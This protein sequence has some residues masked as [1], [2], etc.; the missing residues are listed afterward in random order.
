MVS[1]SF[2]EVLEVENKASKPIEHFEGMLSRP[3]EQSTETR[4]EKPS[5]KV[6]L[7]RTYSGELIL[8]LAR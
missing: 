6:D 3:C 1:L 5:N 4:T 7:E 8:L 2:K